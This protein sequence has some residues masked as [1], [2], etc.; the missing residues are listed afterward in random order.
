M[1]GLRFL[2][3]A[4][5]KV[6]GVGR[7]RRR[8]QE[9]AAGVPKRTCQAKKHHR[10]RKAKGTTTT[11]P[12]RRQTPSRACSRPTTRAPAAA[13]DAWRGLGSRLMKREICNVQCDVQCAI[14]CSRLMLPVGTRYGSIAALIMEALINKTRTTTIIGGYQ[15]LLASQVITSH[16]LPANNSWRKG[17]ARG[18]GGPTGAW[19]R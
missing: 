10:V 11:T 6:A 16:L 18:Q 15:Q 17:A 4:A 19:A 12:G 13:A 9:W 14:Y 1:D 7:V 8:Q 5:V 3:L 2:A